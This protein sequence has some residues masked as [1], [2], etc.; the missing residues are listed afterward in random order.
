MNVPNKDLL[1]MRDPKNLVGYSP[2]PEPTPRWIEPLS[3]REQ[4]PF[5]KF[6]IE[7]IVT[8]SKFSGEKR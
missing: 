6:I 4:K 5:P 1:Y 3:E 7:P 2:N 8:S